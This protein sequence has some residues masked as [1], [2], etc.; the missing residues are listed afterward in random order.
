M[1]KNKIL[2]GLSAL[3]MGTTM[4]A[5][6]AMTASAFSF[7]DANNNPKDGGFYTI[8]E[9]TSGD[10]VVDG[11]DDYTPAPTMYGINMYDGMITDITD[12]DDGTYDVELDSV[13]AYL[14]GTG[15]ITSIT[16]NSTN[17]QIYDSSVDTV[18]TL[19]TNHDYTIVVDVWIA[20]IFHQGT[21]NKTV[22]FRVS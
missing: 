6:T 17:I 10:G 2:A 18:A 13:T 22:Q 16:D 8:W 11:N 20:G 12:N 7:N 3:V 9:D 5:G 1:K 4:M 15:E 14:I 21:H 19:L